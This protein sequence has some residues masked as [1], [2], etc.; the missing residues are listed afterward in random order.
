MASMQRPP[1][2]GKTGDRLSLPKAYVWNGYQPARKSMEARHTEVGGG[3]PASG[4]EGILVERIEE[5][6]DNW[7]LADV[8]I[9]YCVGHFPQ[10][11]RKSWE[12]KPK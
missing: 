11:S 2:L 9:K 7:L 12:I 8:Q 3:G 5:K 1:G 4:K 6:G 10:N